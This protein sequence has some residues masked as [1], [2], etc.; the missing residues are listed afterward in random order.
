[1]TAAP[2]IL[3]AGDRAVLVEFDAAPSSALF[4]HHLAAQPPAEVADL[5]AAEHTVLVVATPGTSRS[6]CGTSL[7]TDSTPAAG[8]TTCSNSLA[9][10]SPSVC[11]TTA[12]ISMMSPASPG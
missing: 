10:K 1:M 7:P 3:P 5:V 6:A 11:T 9:R 12:P 2:R 8:R 4:A